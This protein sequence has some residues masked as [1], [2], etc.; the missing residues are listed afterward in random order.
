M[1]GGNAKTVEVLWKLV[2]EILKMELYLNQLTDKVGYIH[3]LEHYSAS[4]TKY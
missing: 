2:W 1:A 4:E 3:T